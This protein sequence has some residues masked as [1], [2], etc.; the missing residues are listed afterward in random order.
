[1]YLSLEPHDRRLLLSWSN[2]VPWDNKQFTIYRQD[3]G[4]NSFDSIGTS[5]IPSY[6]DKGV[7]NGLL[8]CYKIKST[9]NYSASGFIDPIINFS[10]ETCAIPEDNAPPC[11][12]A[13]TVSTIC[14]ESTNKLMWI[15]PSD[16]CPGDMARYYIYFSPSTTNYVLLDSVINPRD[17]V[18]YH[19]RAESFTGCYYMT[20]K[21]SVGNVSLSG[22]TVCVDLSNCPEFLYRLPN[23]FTPNDDQI[24]DLFE[25]FP[26]KSVS[27]IKLE[28]FDR[29]GR[30]VFS[31]KEPDINWDGHDKTTG[32]P[33]SDGTYFYVCDVYENTLAGIVVRSLHGSLTLLR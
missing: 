9:G 22:D 14:I 21:D 27:E 20:A 30:M 17:S 11:P 2:Q 3:P 13:L 5:P 7:V 31:T 25:P 15:K 32:Q 29:W 10:Q 24:N 6:N 1:M 18:Y 12:P 16:T 28:I 26:Y 8:Y 4:A 19:T 23:V 33:C